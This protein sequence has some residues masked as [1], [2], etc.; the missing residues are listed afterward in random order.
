MKTIICGPPHS[1]KSVL[2]N[3]L[4]WLLPSDS[5]QVIRANGDGEGLWSNNPNQHD[6]QAARKKGTNNPEDFARWQRQIETATQDIVIA[7][8]GGRIGDDKRGL[9]KA[10]DSFVVLSSNPELG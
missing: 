7:D 10:C 3:N 1:G 2:V 5:Y 4:T 9:F 8:I 6:V